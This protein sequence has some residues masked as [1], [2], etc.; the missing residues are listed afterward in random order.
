[1]TAPS[2]VRKTPESWRKACGDWIPRFIHIGQVIVGPGGELVRVSQA[3]RLELVIPGGHPHP[4]VASDPE[5][6]ERGRP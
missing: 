6:G 5:P 4:G 1:M 2:D 3:G